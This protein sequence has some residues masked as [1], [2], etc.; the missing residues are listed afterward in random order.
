MIGFV[1]LLC[2]VLA[3][4]GHVWHIGLVHEE[5]GTAIEMTYG[6]EMRN[7]GFTGV[8]WKLS[9]QKKLGNGLGMS[10][11][12]ETTIKHSPPW[13]RA[14]G[15]DFC[16]QRIEAIYLHADMESTRIDIVATQ[17]PKLDHLG[18]LHIS[19]KGFPEEKLA[20]MV[21]SIR[22]DKLHAA[23]AD[24]D[25]GPKPWLRRTQLK[26]LY[27]SHTQF[28]DEA[29]DDLPVTLE[30]LELEETQLTS[31][32]MAKLARLRNL[33]VLILRKVVANEATYRELKHNLPDCLIDWDPI[34]TPQQKQQR[35]MNE[36]RERRLQ[37][38]REHG[39]LDEKD[40]S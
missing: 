2:G 8:R 25:R 31:L 38:E 4:L 36:R 40:V 26:E 34:E 1:T 19:G 5:V 7:L 37:Y 15:F 20:A 6:E 3:W 9:Q 14:T 28:S 12:V 22:L 30:R 10:S 18:A 29:V 35:R 24:L 39:I 21:G 11:T 32:G 33:R 17:L 13:M 27:L 23:Y 16:W